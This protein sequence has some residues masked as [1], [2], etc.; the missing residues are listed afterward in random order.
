MSGTRDGGTTLRAVM[1]SLPKDGQR[2]VSAAVIKRMGLPTP[3]QA[4]IGA[5]QFS[6]ATFLTNWNRLSPEG[7]R[8]LF[9][10]YGPAFS[11]DMSRIASV[12]DN[13][14]SGA[15]V[16]A[17]PSGTANRSASIT[18]GAALVASLLDPSMATTGTLVAD[19]AGANLTARAFTNPSFVK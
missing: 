16:Y 4:S 8:A 3:G 15:K 11:Q 18:Y 13:I 1:Q 9:D 5:D 12:A 7:R 14:K 2:A 17:N 10:R 19:D 6:A